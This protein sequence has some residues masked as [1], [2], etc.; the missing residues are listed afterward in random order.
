MEKA[1]NMGV[2]NYLEWIASLLVMIPPVDGWRKSK[3]QKL[4][5]QRTLDTEIGLKGQEE[6]DRRLPPLL[7]LCV[8]QHKLLRETATPQNQTNGL[9]S[10]TGDNGGKNGI[11]IHH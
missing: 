3:R 6:L 9:K 1:V 10:Y 4:E 5:E 8:L 11:I 2:G 7:A